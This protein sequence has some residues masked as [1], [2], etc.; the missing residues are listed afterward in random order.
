M[1]E[2]LKDLTSESRHEFVGKFSRSGFKSDFIATTGVTVYKPTLVLTDVV[3]ASSNEQVSD[4]LWFNYTKGFL[5]LG[6]LH[7]GDL[8]KFTARVN[9]YSTSKKTDY[10]LSYPRKISRVDKGSSGKPMPVDNNKA[11]IGYIMEKNKKF[12]IDNNRPYDP[13]YVDQYNDWQKSL[14]N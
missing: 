6:E 1:R 13:W 3:L 12:Y 14:S 5:K 9:N 7:E 11:L 8:I 10:K 4:H 2:E